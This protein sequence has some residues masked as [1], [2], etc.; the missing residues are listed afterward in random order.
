M[1]YL[2]NTKLQWKDWCQQYNDVT[3]AMHITCL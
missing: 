1:Q 3:N 2:K